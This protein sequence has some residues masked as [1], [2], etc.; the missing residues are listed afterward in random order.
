MPTFTPTTPLPKVLEILEVDI[1]WLTRESGLDHSVVRRAV[2]GGK[3]KTNITSALSIASA[4]GMEV[5][6]I[7]W[8]CGLTN[9]GRTAHTGGTYSKSVD[10][11]EAKF[12]QDCGMQLPLSNQCSCA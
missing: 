5:S 9:V 3:M 11:P 2:M 4:L 7:E 10:R 1:K 12:C 6:E 8:P